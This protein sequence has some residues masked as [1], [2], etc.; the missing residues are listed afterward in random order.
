MFSVIDIVFCILEEE[1]KD[2]V[3]RVDI[4]V[5][6]LSYPLIIEEETPLGF[7]TTTVCTPRTI[8]WI[9]TWIV[10]ASTTVALDIKFE[11]KLRDRPSIR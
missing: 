8:G 9:V 5:S 6:V 2:V 1:V 10:L 3:E 7:V 4:S 11:P